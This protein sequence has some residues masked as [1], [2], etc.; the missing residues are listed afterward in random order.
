MGGRGANVDAHALE[1]EHLQ[2]FDVLHDD[3]WA[4]VGE[5]GVLMVFIEIVHAALPLARYHAADSMSL[6]A[7]SYTVPQNLA[8][9]IHKVLRAPRAQTDEAA[10]ATSCGVQGDGGAWGRFAVSTGHT[11]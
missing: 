5:I 2:A 8:P 9:R 11:Q 7:H 3:V 4:Y 6:F 10:A 1:R